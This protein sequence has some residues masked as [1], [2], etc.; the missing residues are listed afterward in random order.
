MTGEGAHVS[1]TE[2]GTTVS[3]IPDVKASVFWDLYLLVARIIMH[4]VC[5]HHHTDNMVLLMSF[6]SIRV[7]LSFFKSGEVSACFLP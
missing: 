7:F 5:K 3:H 6:V 4:A 2:F 1:L